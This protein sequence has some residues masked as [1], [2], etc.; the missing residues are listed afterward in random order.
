MKKLYKKVITIDTNKATIKYLNQ[1]VAVS[2]PKGSIW[3]DLTNTK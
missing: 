1:R 3:I 2:Q